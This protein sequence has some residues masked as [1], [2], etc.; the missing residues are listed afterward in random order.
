M[1]RAQ[2]CSNN[3]ENRDSRQKTHGRLKIAERNRDRA[4]IHRP[5]ACCLEIPAFGSFAQVNIGSVYLGSKLCMRG[6][7]GL[8]VSALGILPV[9]PQ[10]TNNDNAFSGKLNAAGLNGNRWSNQPP[11]ERCVYVY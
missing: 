6:F 11:N 7:V 2:L 1:P 4:C 3:A 10:T 8:M 9:S 5:L